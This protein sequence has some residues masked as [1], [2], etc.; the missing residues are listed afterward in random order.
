MLGKVS[1]KGHYS[2]NNVSGAAHRDMVGMTPNEPIFPWSN[3]ET[4]T[5]LRAIGFLTPAIQHKVI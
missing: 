4:L 5:L 2:A 3:L 1:L